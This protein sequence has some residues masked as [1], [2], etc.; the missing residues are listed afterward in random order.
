MA[1]SNLYGV[2]ISIMKIPT[3]I[4]FAVQ[5]FNR[6][7]QKSSLCSSEQRNNNIPE[8]HTFSHDICYHL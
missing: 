2:I 8:V 4:L 7:L 3:G 5:L 6:Q 1:V